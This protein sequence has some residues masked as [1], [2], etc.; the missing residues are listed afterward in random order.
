[1]SPWT[2]GITMTLMGMGMVFLVL[3][4]LVLILYLFNWVWDRYVEKPGR[5]REKAAPAA[6]G[7]PDA[8]LAA[9]S[10]PQAGPEL[11]AGKVA[12]IAAALAAL[13]PPGRD[14]RAIRIAA[15]QKALRWAASGRE[16]LINQRQQYLARKG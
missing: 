8:G 16:S 14:L 4:V 12:A 9:A 11:T 15:P 7:K 10:L 13:S 6:P 3:T 1:M 5:P 2:L